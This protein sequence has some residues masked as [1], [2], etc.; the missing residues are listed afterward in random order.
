MGVD[1]ID[2]KYSRNGEKKPEKCVQAILLCTSAK[3]AAIQFEQ[4]AHGINEH[5][6]NDIAE[7]YDP[8]KPK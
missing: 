4:C 8:G 2:Y 6:P 3:L 1:Q 7:P 5:K